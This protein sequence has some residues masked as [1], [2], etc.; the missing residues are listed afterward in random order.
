M[1]E[2]SER[3]CTGSF[4]FIVSAEWD[5]VS[6][7]LKNKYL[8]DRYS[9]SMTERLSLE[10]AAKMLIDNGWK[11]YHCVEDIT[12]RNWDKKKGFNPGIEGKKRDETKD[13]LYGE[14]L[15]FTNKVRPLVY[16]L[17]DAK[18]GNE[19][20]L[21]NLKEKKPASVILERETAP[22]EKNQ[23]THTNRYLLLRRW[24]DGSF[25]L[26]SLP[27]S[28]IQLRLYASGVM[29]LSICCNHEINA[30]KNNIR[31]TGIEKEKLIYLSTDEMRKALPVSLDKW[32]QTTASDIAW[33]RDAGR[34]LFWPYACIK[35]AYYPREAPAYSALQLG[36]ES[37][38]LCDYRAILDAGETY[39]TKPEYFDWTQKLICDHCVTRMK[40]KG[41]KEI[42]PPGNL[43]V[44]QY[45]NDDRMY[46]HNTIV[47]PEYS[48]LVKEGWAHRQEITNANKN[49]P[50]LRAAWEKLRVWYAILAADKN[51][52]DATCQDAD[53]LIRKCEE[54]T[55]ARW[56]DY[57]SF[58]GLYYNA[59]TQLLK[60]DGS[61]TFS[62][63]MDW[64]YYQMF[65]LAIMQRSSIQRFYR[66]ASGTAVHRSRRK[67]SKLSNALKEKYVFFM[68]SM[69]FTEVTEQEQG[70]DFFDKL[71]TNMA[72]EQDMALL[73]DAIEEL[74]AVTESNLENA[75]NNAL[76]PATIVG[77]IVNTTG[78]LA[79]LFTDQDEGIMN[80]FTSPFPWL[81]T[82]VGVG[83]GLLVWL[84]Y[85]LKSK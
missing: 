51:W 62:R 23:E 30:G 46:L 48:T 64:M 26:Y 21:K 47:S 5:Y 8:K 59:I 39:I 15:Y 34:R 49:T 58:Y 73:K 78:G 56:M 80:F 42:L 69:W 4:S 19:A 16:N 13:W 55:D 24:D 82:G 14:F 12:A 52:H 20:F 70:Y 40:M 61:N 84:Y 2:M 31:K 44:I 3:K 45:F 74:N 76:I 43:L 41:D 6:K 54:A 11:P 29:T 38:I 65:L 37:I 81:L 36:E 25:T 67:A 1:S 32:D 28:S 68:N 9:I 33:I 77:L 35:G 53:M 66:E 60:N 79:Y 57:G 27:L 17:C 83:C 75:V 63:N 72:L 71:R 50:E 85:R 18:D 10:R 22:E 7:G